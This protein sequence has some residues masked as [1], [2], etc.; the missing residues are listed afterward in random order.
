MRRAIS[1]LLA[2][3][4][5]ENKRKRGG[6]ERREANYLVASLAWKRARPRCDPRPRRLNSHL[7]ILLIS[8]VA[9]RSLQITV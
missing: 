9:L 3:V 5:Q 7:L 2:E 6:E 4:E 1:R 8:S